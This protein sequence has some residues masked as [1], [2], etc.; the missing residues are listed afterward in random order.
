M[1]TIIPAG[2]R[3][4]HRSPGHVAQ[5]SAFWGSGF[6]TIAT[7]ALLFSLTSL[8]VKLIGD[9][10]PV[11][12]TVLLPG[13]VCFAATSCVA[14]TYSISLRSKSW[15]V[16]GL[17][18]ARGLLGATSII[19]FYLALDRLPLADAVTLFFCSPVLAALFELAATRVSH[20]W[21]G[22]AATACTV[23]GV[24]L[25]AQPECVFAHGHHHMAGGGSTSAAGV[26]LATAAATANAVRRALGGMG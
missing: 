5:L 21:G 18:L 7:A 12:Q 24:F 11:F 23:V 4:P 1:T 22:A 6:A 9:D 25:V 17:T 8:S 14:Q 10:V 26:A 3:R 19:C 16:A 2:A 13:L 20:G 15:H